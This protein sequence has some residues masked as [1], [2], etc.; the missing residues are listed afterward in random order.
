MPD[1]MNFLVLRKDMIHNVL[2][3]YLIRV[4]LINVEVIAPFSALYLLRF[5]LSHGR[6]LS[7]INRRSLGVE[8]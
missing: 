7:G 1:H 8:C 2:R 3:D 4:Y 5:S 6:D